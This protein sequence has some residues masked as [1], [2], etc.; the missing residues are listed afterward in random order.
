MSLLWSL[1]ILTSCTWVWFPTTA[2]IWDAL[3]LGA[4]QLLLHLT[5]FIFS[6]WHYP[7]R[8]TKCA[9]KNSIIVYR[10]SLITRMSRSIKW[11]EIPIISYYVNQ[12]QYFKSWYL[13]YY[14][15][16]GISYKSKYCKD[17]G[18]QNPDNQ[19]ILNSFWI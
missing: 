7:K 3:F 6:K 16:G 14:T 9:K 17:Y 15:M 11:I 18:N 4:S 2:Q 1:A 13:R 12:T 8:Y 10:V 5:S 19:G